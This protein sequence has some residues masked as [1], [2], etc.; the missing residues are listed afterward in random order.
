[1]GEGRAERA[2][3]SLS[4]AGAD[5]GTARR[6]DCGKWV[7]EL[8]S[9]FAGRKRVAIMEDNDATGRAHV[10]EVAEALRGIV[11]DIRLVTFRDLPEHGDLTDWKECN[12]SHAVCS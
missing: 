11:P 6:L 8:N 2:Q 5:Q 12:H 3:D 4:L 7:P 1:M 10:L 9:W